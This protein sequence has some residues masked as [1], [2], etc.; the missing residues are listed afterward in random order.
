[1]SI[2]CG[3]QCHVAKITSNMT[4]CHA[5]HREQG[6]K[7]AQMGEKTT[8]LATISN[9]AA[10]PPQSIHYEASCGSR[11]VTSDR[12]LNGHAVRDATIA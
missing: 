1:M 11:E 5:K 6:L 10:G 3:R 9:C 4:L 7:L 8:G 2:K 12:R